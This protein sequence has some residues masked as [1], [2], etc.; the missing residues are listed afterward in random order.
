MRYTKCV[1]LSDYNDHLAA[2]VGGQGPVGPIIVNSLLQGLLF[3]ALGAGIGALFGGAAAAFLGWIFFNYGFVD[4]V[5]DQWLNWR[6][7]CIEQN[8]CVAGRIAFIETVDKKF[9][10]DLFSVEYFFDNDLSFNVRMMPFTAKTKGN[11]EFDEN[12]FRLSSEFTAKQIVDSK[13]EAGKRLDAGS[14]LGKQYDGYEGTKKPNH[15]GGRWTMHCEIEGNG[16]HMLCTWAKVI[17]VLGP[18]GQ[19]LSSL[20]GGAVLAWVFGRKAAEVVWAGCKKKCKVPILCDIVCAVAAA[21]AAVVGGIV[22]LAIGLIAGAI[23]G[24]GALFLGTLI[25]VF[26]R[27]DGA[28][29]DVQNNPESGNIEKGDCVVVF[30]DQVYDAGHSEGWSEIHPVVQLQKMC[31]V[32]PFAAPEECCPGFLTTS[33]DFE[34]Q[35]K[36][37]ENNALWNR[38]CS[39]L[40]EG[41]RADVIQR[42]SSG[43]SFF[44]LHPLV[45]GCQESHEPVVVK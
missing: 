21:V 37:D 27:D 35:A 8:T 22:G 25:S 40:K 34:D 29:K 6:L 17:A 28:W 10:N 24:L 12:D 9:D 30:G 1:S 43:S 5:C 4:G 19:G 33:A 23:P 11:W 39:A 32:E 16:M 7:I 14:A 20:A 41:R 3:G 45:D 44:I 38:W 42:Q 13:Y 2:S 36:I 15:P 31:V 18:F 26:F